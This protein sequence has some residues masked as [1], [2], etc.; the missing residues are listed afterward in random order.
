MSSVTESL[1]RITSTWHADPAAIPERPW[2]GHF[3]VTFVDTGNTAEVEVK[4]VLRLTGALIEGRGRSPEFPRN[5]S[6][7]DREFTLTG[8][9][10]GSRV[11]FDLWFGGIAARS[12]FTCEGVLNEAEDYI[13]GTWSYACFNPETCGCRGGHGKFQMEQCR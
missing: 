6:D 2:K 9:R 5:G 12:A 3:D 7:S 1:E 11:V 8:S 13:E 4:S 10:K